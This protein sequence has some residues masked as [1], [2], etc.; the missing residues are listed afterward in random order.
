[1]NYKV[2]LYA[3]FLFVSIFTLS[4][5]NFEKFMKKDKVIEARLLI[6]ILAFITSYLLTNFVYDFLNL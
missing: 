2:Y 5:I 1:M 4:G 3:V 6:L